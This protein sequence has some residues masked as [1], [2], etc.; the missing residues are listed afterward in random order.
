[1]SLCEAASVFIGPE[2]VKIRMVSARSRIAI[3]NSQNFDL[4][5]GMSVT[6]YI[7]KR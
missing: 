5:P 2:I 4:V 7:H 1:L 6:V 3:E